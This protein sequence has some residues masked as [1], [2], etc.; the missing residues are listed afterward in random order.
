M[1]PLDEA[2]EVL[3][4]E[5]AHVATG[6]EAEQGPAWEAAYAAISA[7]YRRRGDLAGVSFEGNL[8][9]GTRRH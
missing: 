7:E 3:A 4:H 9:D 1:L 2:T 8:P 5:L 6:I